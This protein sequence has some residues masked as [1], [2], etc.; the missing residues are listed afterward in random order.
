MLAAGAEPPGP[1]RSVIRLGLGGGAPPHGLR[2]LPLHRPPPHDAL[3]SLAEAAESVEAEAAA[4]RAAAARAARALPSSSPGVRW[5]AGD[6]DP[7][8]GPPA[9][10]PPRDMPRSGSL[11]R[12]PPPP[13]L[14][15]P[16]PPHQPP[17]L[18]AEADEP[19]PEPG[20]GGAAQ[21]GGGDGAGEGQQGSD[22]AV[23]GGVGAPGGVVCVPMDWRLVQT[24]D[25]RW[26]LLDS[27][28]PGPATEGGE[29]QAEAAAAARGGGGGGG[30]VLPGPTVL[31]LGG[32]ADVGGAPS[33]SLSSSSLAEPSNGRVLTAVLGWV[34]EPAAAAEGEAPE[35]GDGAG[36]TGSEDGGGEPRAVGVRHYLLQPLPFTAEELGLDPESL[37]AVQT[38]S[39][40]VLPRRRDG[41]A[42][43]EVGEAAA[44]AAAGDVEP[45]PAQPAAGPAAA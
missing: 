3:S 21:G 10:A 13:P 11:G 40:V 29:R 33:S 38:G 19:A 26:L 7:W 24:D 28:Q 14:A 12:R 34:G 17:H 6:E 41:G 37:P 5:H 31:S 1:A 18:A 42:G 4:A 32:D 45:L 44:V 30:G 23:A 15:V 27:E 20:Q 22:A 9:A 43:G 35:R 8:L 25:G 2:A 36:G 39:L 16:S